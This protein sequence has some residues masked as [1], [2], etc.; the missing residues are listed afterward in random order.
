[1]GKF[2]GIS[3]LTVSFFY[4]YNKVRVFLKT[5]KKEALLKEAQIKKQR[6]YLNNLK[7]YSAINYYTICLSLD[8]KVK[9]NF[10]QQSKEVVNKVIFAKIKDFLTISGLNATTKIVEDVLIISSGDF[11][12]YD[13][14]YS[15]LLKVLSKIKPEVDDRYEICM[16]PNITTDAYAIRPDL[17]HIRQNHMNIKHC[18][19]QNTSCATSAFIK[20]Y[21]YLNKSKYIGSPIGEY[22]VV[23]N[24]KTN[25]Y[26]LNMVYKDLSKQLES[27]GQ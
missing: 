20:K 8:Y 23:D 25:N 9:R 1:M 14:I 16:I 27:L 3:L 6:D 12:M 5:K 10:S 17:E 21:K 7:Q 11:N 13:N 24:E 18:N 26:E 2:L 22:S 19:L 15:K 4:L